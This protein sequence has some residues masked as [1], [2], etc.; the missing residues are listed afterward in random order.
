VRLTASGFFEGVMITSFTTTSRGAVQIQVTSRAPSAI[1]QAW[2]LRHRPAP[3]LRRRLSMTP[4]TVFC[5][6]PFRGLYGAAM[7]ASTLDQILKPSSC[8]ADQG[9]QAVHVEAGFEAVRECVE[10]VGRFGAGRR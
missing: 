8:D 5:G 6:P 10:R 9:V 7:T 1:W 2:E 3:H 4:A